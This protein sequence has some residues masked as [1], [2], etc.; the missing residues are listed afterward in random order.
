MDST[1]IH[2]DKNCFVFAMAMLIQKILSLTVHSGD[3]IPGHVSRLIQGLGR[4]SGPHSPHGPREIN[5][6]NLV[7]N[8]I[9]L[10]FKLNSFS[11]NFLL[12]LNVKSLYS[13]K[14]KLFYFYFWIDL[15]LVSAR[16]VFYT[17][18]S[19]LHTYISELL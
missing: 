19:N 12:C 7:F 15:I 11:Q 13:R 1:D 14:N 10:V 6:N 3:W 4:P 5:Q 2:E 9:S 8:V 17:K 18:S 16:P